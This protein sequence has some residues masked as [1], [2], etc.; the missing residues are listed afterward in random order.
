ME[1]GTVAVRGEEVSRHLRQRAD[2][3]RAFSVPME[4][5]V[6]SAEC[7]MYWSL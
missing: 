1:I 7:G 4:D 6:G 2:L 5:M 3:A